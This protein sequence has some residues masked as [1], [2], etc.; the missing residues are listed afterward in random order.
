MRLDGIGSDRHTAEIMGTKKG[1]SKP[2][3]SFIERKGSAVG[4]VL[5]TAE[6][7]EDSSGCTSFSFT[8][9][10]NITLAPPFN[11]ANLQKQLS[12]QGVAFSTGTCNCPS[13]PI[14]IN[15]NHYGV[16]LNPFSYTLYAG[17]SY[18]ICVQNGD[19]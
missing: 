5:A 16:N 6:S 2:K 7:L 1:S 13:G 14:W 9:N 18:T 19:N 4:V 17:V 12:A 11:A 3:P 10:K 8:P 15:P